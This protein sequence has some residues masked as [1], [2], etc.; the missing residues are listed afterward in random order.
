MEKNK[1]K[2]REL[3]LCSLFTALIAI[4]A[5]I[6][7]PVPVVP[8]TLQ[9]AFVILAGILLGAKLGAI[10]VIIYI[11]LGLIGL[12]IFTNG[13]G[14]AYVLQ[15]TFGYII[16]FA[17][18]AF[19]IGKISNST[20]NP[21]VKRLL[22]ANI[23]GLIVIYALGATYY[24]AISHLYLGTNIGIGS[25]MLYC[26]ILCLPGDIFICFFTAILGNKLVTILNRQRRLA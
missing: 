5:F 24:Y 23:V 1:L 25:L 21:S 8:F 15:P 12:P 6:K 14:I 10:S 3:I 2:T 9:D 17:I 11:V 7:I 22:L 16:G 26:V 20:P 4:G 13:G 18:A 19:I